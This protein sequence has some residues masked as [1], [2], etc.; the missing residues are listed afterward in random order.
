[1]TITEKQVNFLLE[2]FFKNERYPG[3]KNIADK[4]IR[5]GQCIIA[6]TDKLW[7]GGVGNFIDIKEAPGTV[8]CSLL[9]FKKDVFLKSINFTDYKKAYLLDLSNKITEMRNTY[10]HVDT[11]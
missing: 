2:N 1:M 4:L 6:G 11:L 3:W 8:G 5:D 9:T 7:Y 10:E